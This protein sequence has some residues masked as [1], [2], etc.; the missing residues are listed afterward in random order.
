MTRRPYIPSSLLQYLSLPLAIYL[1]RSLRPPRADPRR[2]APP[3][4]YGAVVGARSAAR[5]TWDPGSP[6]PGEAPRDG[7]RAP[8][9]GVDV[10]PPL[11]EPP[12]PGKRA[13]FGQKGPK[14]PKSPKKGILGTFSGFRGFLGP[15]GLPGDPPEGWFY[16][17]PSRRGPVPGG[18]RPEGSWSQPRPGA[19]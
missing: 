5:Q 8:A 12:K 6:G 15:W 10:K 11:P 3:P 18:G 16:I 7:D 17:N 14:R 13:Y 1:M 9:R 4:L 19:G 2:S